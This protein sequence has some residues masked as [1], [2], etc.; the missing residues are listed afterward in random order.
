MI[1]HGI[2]EGNEGAWRTGALVD[3][4]SFR[5]SLLRGLGDDGAGDA[6]RRGAP[7]F[8]G[9]GVNDHRGAAVAEDGVASSPSVTWGATTVA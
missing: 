4:L 6:R 2:A 5:E 9:Y 7:G 8:G 1:G 3:S